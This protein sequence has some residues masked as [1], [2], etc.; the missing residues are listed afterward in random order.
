M[1][2]SMIKRAYDQ[3]TVERRFKG[4]QFESVS[5]YQKARSMAPP[6]ID[7]VYL[8]GFKLSEEYD[9]GRYF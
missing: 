4:P 9:D 3:I 8:Y 2:K 5:T 7:E 6:V 1:K